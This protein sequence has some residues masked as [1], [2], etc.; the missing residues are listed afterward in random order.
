M[1]VALNARCAEALMGLSHAAFGALYLSDKGAARARIVAC[2]QA[3]LRLQGA[4]LLHLC[5][6]EDTAAA[7]AGVCVTEL[8]R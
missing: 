5:S 7:T 1:N 4:W 2:Q 8:P 6:S 3:A